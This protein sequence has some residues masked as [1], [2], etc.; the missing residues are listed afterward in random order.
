MS[1]GSLVDALAVIVK[2]SSIN[3]MDATCIASFMQSSTIDADDDMVAP[4]AGVY[5][6][7]SGGIIDT[8]NGLLER[9]ETLLTR[10]T[11]INSSSLD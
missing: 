8:L 11:S 2:A 3:A 9:G 7:A 10:T 1:A 6:S 5:E 4:D